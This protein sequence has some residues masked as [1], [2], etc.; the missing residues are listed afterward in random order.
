MK[1]GLFIPCYVDLLFPE[2]GIATL[3]LLER[4]DFEVGYP[5]THTCCGQ[6]MSNSGDEAN[7]A[8]AERLFVENFKEFDWIV[9]PAGSCVKQVRQHFDAIEQTDAVQHVR[10]QT[11]ELVEFL[12]D[13]AKVPDFPRGGVPPFGGTPQQLQLRSRAGTGEALRDHGRPF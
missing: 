12:H 2:V 3:E 11:Y 5:L 6:P 1:I 4:L 10:H 8:R 9:G 7:A 13:I